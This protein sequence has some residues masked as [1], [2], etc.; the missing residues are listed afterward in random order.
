MIT[1]LPG[2]AGSPKVFAADVLS[3]GFLRQ[4]VYHDIP[5]Y[6]IS[7]LSNQTKFPDSPDAVSF[8]ASFES[9]LSG[10]QNNAVR[11]TGFLV[12]QVSGRHVVHLSGVRTAVLFL[13]PN[14][15]PALK[16][17]IAADSEWVGSRYW[18]TDARGGRNTEEN[19]SA[20]VAL[21]AGR[22]YYV[23]LVAKNGLDALAVGVNWRLEG[24]PPPPNFSPPIGGSLLATYAD[25]A[26][27]TLRWDRQPAPLTVTEGEPA[28][29]QVRV[30]ASPGPITYQWQRQGT[31]IPGAVY[32]DFS[33][34][35][36]S[37]A[38]D[39][40]A[41]RCIVRIPGRTATSETATLR[42]NPDTQPARVESAEGGVALRSVT[43]RFSEHLDPTDA[44][45]PTLFAIDGDLAVTAARLLPDSRSIRLR[46]TPQTSGREYTVTLRGLRDAAVAANRMPQDSRIAFVAWEPEEEPGPF[47]SWWD[48][49]RDFGA[50]GDGTTDD[51]DA[52]QQALDS[53]GFSGNNP[54]PKGVLHVP[55]GTY[56]ITRTLEFRSRFGAGVVGEDPE[57]TILR[58]DGPEDG[59]LLWVDGTRNMRS[60]R[61]TLDGRSRAL[62]LIDQKRGSGQWPPSENEF[63]D[64]ILRDAKNGI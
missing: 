23:E 4:E 13:S 17:R 59:V 40:I 8:L 51:T 43:L 19:I 29:F 27:A 10:E 34:A 5:G 49:K 16:T 55:A 45:D 24:D 61:L 36:T 14:D 12:P 15:D 52:W 46:T 35:R 60:S 3:P 28:R 25:P 21:E 26:N 38:E 6:E 9:V 33:L 64:L 11:I 42:V 2:A 53:L 56:R 47:A 41:Y 50:V 37:L 62:S 63:S 31:D 39:G 7:D 22:R 32:P 54:Q 58:W 57:T 48:V 30:T 20:P 44:A 1:L 18:T